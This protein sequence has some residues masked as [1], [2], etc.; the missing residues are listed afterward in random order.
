MDGK[1][2]TRGNKISLRGRLC[3]PSPCIF[4]ISHFCRFVK[5]FFEIFQNIFS[6]AVYLFIIMYRYRVLKISVC[7][8]TCLYYIT[9]LR[10]CQV[11][12]ENFSEKIFGRCLR[13]YNIMNAPAFSDFQRPWREP[14]AFDTLIIAHLWEFVNSFFK[15]FW[16]IFFN[17]NG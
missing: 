17:L 5:R 13:V 11:F 12:F 9:G 10:F 14:L 16:K 1:P 3:R 7:L 2:S 8:L 6:V 4:I 15:N